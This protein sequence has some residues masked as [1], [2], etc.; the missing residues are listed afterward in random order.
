MFTIEISDDI[1]RWFDDVDTW[2]RLA[3]GIPFRETSWLQ[4]WWQTVGQGHTARVVIA[5]DAEGRVRGL[6]PMYLRAD[7][8]T[9]SMM[10]DGDACSDHV[11]VLAEPADAVDVAHAMGV[12]LAR[13]SGDITREWQF[14]EIDG[15]VE[16]DAAMVAFASAL[17][18]GGCRLHG[19]SRMSVWFRPASPS[20]DEHLMT[21]GKTQ[22]RQMK[23]W[24]KALGNVEKVVA[25]NDQQVD[26]LL[27]HLIVMHQRRW[28]EAGQ[29]GSYANQPYCEFIRR[30]AKDFLR[31]DRLY[32]AV[33]KHEGNVIAGELKMIGGNG[34]MYSYSAGYDVDYAELEPGRLMCVDG[35][36]EMYRRG[37]VAID[38]M[39]GDEIYKTRLA[40]DS[41]RLM[42]V[43]AVSPA[44][45]PRLKFAAW[46]V[47][48]AAKQWLRKRCGRPL[49]Q[50]HD[51]SQNTSKP[52]VLPARSTD[53]SMP[54]VVPVTMPAASPNYV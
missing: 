51:P 27:D 33:L 24:A 45:V 36:L 53:S 25:K 26:E 4:P 8:G 46:K 37:G 23:K 6:M 41:R 9:L 50:V 13:C 7:S 35:I 30:S 44:L 18:S 12:A 10:G 34:V 11:S 47:G 54:V 48:F 17:K 21:H 28:N 16:G 43:R 31:R 40:N 5:R 32:L 1:D 15:I 14:I 42:L 19:Q 29:R 2:N 20:W 39:R 52:I 22:R 38:F 3:G 49:V